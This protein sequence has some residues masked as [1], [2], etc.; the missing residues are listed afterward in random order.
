[1]ALKEIEHIIKA[2]EAGRI[3]KVIQNLTN[4][5]RADIRGLFDHG[6]VSLDGAVCL[7]A[8]L[9]VRE[10]SK[11]ALKYD[12]HQRY[13]ERSQFKSRFFRI[14]HEDVHLLVVEKHAGVLTVPTLRGDKENLEAAI[15]IYLGR[16]KVGKFQAFVVHRLDRDTSGLLVFGKSEKI[17]LQLKS[18][19]ED[20]KPIREYL[21]IVS[22]R[23]DQKTGTFK[24]YLSTDE[25]LNQVSS[26]DQG[27]GKLAITH[28]EVVELLKDTTL[29]KVTLE[30]G[31]RNQIRVHFA[32]A[33]HPVLGDTRYKPIMAKHRHWKHP[34]LA[35]HAAKLGF[36]HPVTLKQITFESKWPIEFE[37]FLRTQ[38]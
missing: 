36:T 35:L 5:S 26:Q 21:A 18:Q 30:T 14:V 9:I 31:R 6:C 3:D 24:S 32:E 10:K 29:V 4:L 8:G 17:A 12:P 22:G 19:F 38:R 20:H 34:R 28:F 2:D 37:Q 23:L 15:T 13:K 27:K 25:D 11:V 33:G 16:G 7:D 1:M